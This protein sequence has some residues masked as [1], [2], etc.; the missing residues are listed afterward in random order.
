M[1]IDPGINEH[2]AYA[3][4]EAFAAGRAMGHAEGQRD[5]R[6][7]IVTY[8]RDNK[9]MPSSEARAW[10]YGFAE[11]VETGAFNGAAREEKP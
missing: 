1:S 2:E 5:E 11:V 3:V 8:L 6:E 4:A 10:A 9:Q 7:R